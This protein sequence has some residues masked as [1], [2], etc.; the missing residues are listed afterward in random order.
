MAFSYIYLPFHF[1]LWPDGY[2][3]WSIFGH[4]PTTTNICQ[5]EKIAKVYLK[6]CQ[7]LNKPNKKPAKEYYDILAKVAKCRPVWS[8][9]YAT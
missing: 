8:H 4:L 7:I 6:F 2:I 1:W 9:C 5:A 3:M